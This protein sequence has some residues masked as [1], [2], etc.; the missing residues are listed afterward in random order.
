MRSRC[1]ALG[2]LAPEPPVLAPLRD[3]R[4]K[5]GDGFVGPTGPLPRIVALGKPLHVYVDDGKK[6]PTG[7]YDLG[8]HP[9]AVLGIDE[10]DEV[11]VVWTDDTT[12]TACADDIRT[13]LD[14][15][16]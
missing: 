4:D 14:E 1:S 5:Y 7:G 10:D 2:R 15:D 16:S 13:L 3:H 8:G 9:A 12:A 11:T 6:L